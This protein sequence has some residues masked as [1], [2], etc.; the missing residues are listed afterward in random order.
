MGLFDQL[1]G[2]LLGGL[3][4]GAGGQQSPLLGA[5][6]QMLE[7]QGGLQG[8]LNQLTSGGLGT[9]VASWV[10]P[11]DNHPVTADQITQALGSDKVKELAAQAGLPVDQAAGGLAQILPQLIDHLTPQGQVPSSSLLAEAVTLLKGKLS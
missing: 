1:A 11:G 2:S 10:S 5:A 9:Q 4:G 3:T 7:G 8:L 6:L